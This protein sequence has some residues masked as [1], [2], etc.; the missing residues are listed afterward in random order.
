V[1]YSVCWM[2]RRV[3]SVC[4]GGGGDASTLFC[5]LKAVEGRLWREGCGGKAVEGGLCLWRRCAV[6]LLCL[7]EVVEVSKVMRCVWVRFDMV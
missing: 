1:C 6:C 4:G 3:G 5:M 2:M 7:L